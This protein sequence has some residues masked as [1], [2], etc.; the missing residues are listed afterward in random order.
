M[1]T[2]TTTGLDTRT[3]AAQH[4]VIGEVALRRRDLDRVAPCGHDATGLMGFSV[5]GRDLSADGVADRWGNR[6]VAA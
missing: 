2:M 4:L 5:V 1:A 6:A 3:D